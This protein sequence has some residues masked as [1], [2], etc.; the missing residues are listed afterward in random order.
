MKGW[1]IGRSAL[2]AAKKDHQGRTVG[3]VEN[4]SRTSSCAWPMRIQYRLAAYASGTVN[5]MVR[6]WFVLAETMCLQLHDT[7]VILSHVLDHPWKVTESF[8]LL[9]Y[10]DRGKGRLPGASH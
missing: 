9:P 3:E 4:R 5:G 1:K 10:I 6:G 2:L 7:L 8:E